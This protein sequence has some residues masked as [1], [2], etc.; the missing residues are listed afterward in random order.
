MTSYI[1]RDAERI[2]RLAYG[3]MP[4]EGTMSPVFLVYAVLLRAKGEDVTPSDVHDAW[5]ACAEIAGLVRPDLVPWADLDA[6]AQELDVPFADAIH[7][8][9][10]SIGPA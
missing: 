4:P 9:A 5:A 1:R 8:A 2:R 7:Q 10:R 6:A 3:S